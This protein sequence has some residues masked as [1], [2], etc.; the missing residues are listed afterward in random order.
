MN[1]AAQRRH[2]A[3]ELLEI[4]I[5]VGQ[6]VVLDVAGAIAQRLEHHIERHQLGEAGWVA[7]RVGICCLQHVAGGSVNNDG[8]VAIRADLSLCSHRMHGQH[9]GQ[10]SRG[11]GK[12]RSS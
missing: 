11:G 5:E 10:S 9:G 12:A 3:L 2:L 8:A 1:V 7:D 4:E 6:G